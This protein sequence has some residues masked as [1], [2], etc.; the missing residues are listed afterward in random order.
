M[1][2]SEQAG[3]IQID[4]RIDSLD[5]LRGVA[6]CGI[7]LM[8]IPAMGGIWERDRP[9]FPSVFN[10]DWTAFE[11]QRFFFEGSMRG[12]F[13]LLFGAGM[14]VMLR[15]TERDGIAAPIDVF[16]RRCIALMFLG[17]VQWLVFLWPGEI[18][19]NYGLTGF[20]ILAFR[21]A[22]PKRLFTLSLVLVALFSL[23]SASEAFE[24]RD[25]FQAAASAEAVAAQH[26]PL[27][28]EQ[29]GAIDAKK[30]IMERI[31]PSPATIAKEVKQR[32]QF[33]SVVSW[34]AKVWSEFNIG[35]ESWFGLLES[36]MFM[37]FGMGLFRLGVLTG[38]RSL[39]FYVRLAVIG[40]GIG[41]PIRIAVQLLMLRMGLNFDFGT[42]LFRAVA[43]EPARLLV[44]V[45][46][47]GFLI[48]LFKL[49]ALGRAWPARALGRMA[50]TTYSLQ[51]I[52]TSILF[53]GFGL[54]N[55]FGFAQLMGIAAAIWIVTGVFAVIWLKSHDQ[56]PAERFL[57]RLAYGR[58]A[59]GPEAMP[60]PDGTLAT[61]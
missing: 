15:K 58:R 10:V 44:T 47:V 50:L 18:L 36:F 38:E 16:V 54:L 40:Y 5:L 49:G 48:A 55:R 45:G 11:L 41:V 61:A 26:K 3:S 22:A 27:T 51:S 34:S 23:L 42:M 29:Q 31:D 46:H 13:T 25:K 20:F 4:E 8:N 19:F 56:G 7:L 30:K 35:G 53:Y 37:L 21:K 33:P 57:R 24:Y 17:I 14:L 9:P 2:T 1:A 6:I 32:T 39:G 60:G 43:Y 12:L 52:L 59:A 28:K